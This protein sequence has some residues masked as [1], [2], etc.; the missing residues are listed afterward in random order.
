MSP[1]GE[2]AMPDTVA[3][4]GEDDDAPE[5]ELVCASLEPVLVPPPL[6]AIRTARQRASTHAAR[7][8]RHHIER[9]TKRRGP[10]FARRRLTGNAPTRIASS[11]SPAALQPLCA[12]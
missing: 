11:P 5:D 7:F 8:G 1:D 2:T 9:S 10:S 6:H 3:P 12:L 4:G